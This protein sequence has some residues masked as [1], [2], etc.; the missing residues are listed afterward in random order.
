MLRSLE[1]DRLDALQHGLRDEAIRGNVSAAMAVA[2]IVEARARV[3]GLIGT[4]TREKRQRCRQ[5][6]T[7]G[8]QENDCRRRNCAIHT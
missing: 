8:L 6:Q 3:L 2:C 4:G 7:V 1:V 5:P